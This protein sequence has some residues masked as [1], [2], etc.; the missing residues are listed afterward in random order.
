MENKLEKTSEFSLENVI[1]TAVKIPGIKVNRSEFLASTFRELDLPIQEV[2]DQGPIAAGCSRETLAE[3][4]NKLILK[5]TSESSIAS[6]LTGLPGGLAMAATIPADVLQF[7]GMALRLAQ[8]LAYLYGAQD[9]WNQGQVD[10]ERVRDQLILY[11]GV[12]FG[13]SGATAGVRVLTTQVAKTA[14]NKIPQK[15]FAKTFWF[16]ILKKIGKVLSIKVT[17][18]TVAKGVSK[19]I[20]VIGGVVSGGLNFASMMPMAKRLHRTLDRTCFDYTEGDLAQD[21]EEIEHIDATAVEP[22]E[23]LTDG[24]EAAK[25]RVSKGFRKMSGGLTGLLGKKTSAENTDSVSN[26]ADEILENIQKLA[27]LK[28]VGIITQEEFEEK[29]MELLARI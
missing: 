27:H 4:A 7:F 29:K 11:C 3:L 10:D 26:P 17:K 13:V 2:L 20:P 9:L 1:T 16:Q 8:E 15:T 23:T 28:E 18:S 19:A 22:G 6:F 21:L 24:L 14:L 25:E 12:M 5:R